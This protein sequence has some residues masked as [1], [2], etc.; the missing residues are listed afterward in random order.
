MINKVD[1]ILGKLVTG[2]P[3]Y[4]QELERAP[5]E[6]KDDHYGLID[7]PELIE[8]SLNVIKNDYVLLVLASLDGRRYGNTIL[9]NFDQ[10]GLT[11][12]KPYNF[13][14]GAIDAF[15]VYFKDI[16]GV[17]SFFQV[18]I[19]STSE[20]DSTICASHPGFLYRLQ[21]RRYHRVDVPEGTRVV[22]WQDDQLRVEGFVRDISAGGMLICSGSIEGRL[23]A[24]AVI[25]EITITLPSSSS[26]WQDEARV[27]LP[28]IKK[29]RIVRTSKGSESNQICHGVAFETDDES[30]EEL[31]SCIEVIK[32]SMLRRG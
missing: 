26:L 24:D 20:S 12:E 22:F 8:K 17:W 7:S 23:Q 15:R 32:D 11:I 5:W 13:D 21:G 29:G 16:L 14:D 25:N 2:N 31:N 1:S 6:I 28:V 3:L 10:D 19:I 9:I 30:E 4:D 18:Q 27:V